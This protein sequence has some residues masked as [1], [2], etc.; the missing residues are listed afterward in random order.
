M[1]LSVK[2]IL[3][4]LVC[5]ATLALTGCKKSSS[6]NYNVSVSVSGLLGTGLYLQLNYVN[7]TQPN[8]AS[9]APVIANGVVTFPNQLPN[10]AVY[11]VNV[12][13]PPGSP[14]QNCTLAN[15]SGTIA[16]AN[17][18]NITLTCASV[19]F[20]YLVNSAANQI[21]PY[22][23]DLGTGML[24][25]SG[26]SLSAGTAPSALAL[27]PTGRYAY[28]VSSTDSTM[29]AYLGNVST[30]QLI[31]AGSAVSTGT[32]GNPSAVVVEP[33]SQYVYVAN[34][35][36]GTVAGF[37]INSASAA[38]T[39]LGAVAGVCPATPTA[40]VGAAPAAMTVTKSASGS[41]YLFVVNS[42]GNSVSEFAINSDGSLSGI[43]AA[44]TGN[45][46]SAIAATPGSVTYVYVTN[47]S[48]DTVSGY[49]NNSG[50]LAANS[51]TALPA[52][53]MPS[54]LA[55][56]PNGKFAY[57][58][59]S[60]NSTV[61]AFSIDGTGALVGLGTP[62]AAGTGN[63]PV[64]VSVDASGAYAYV[65]S[66]NSNT[67]WLYKINTDGTLTAASSQQIGNA[68]VAL[69]TAAN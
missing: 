56:T 16:D 68:P 7:G 61:A 30:G 5:C 23:I 45:N 50:A 20:A 54:A 64:S 38:V 33:G 52:G 22:T 8:V 15:A 12:L 10:N 37:A 35:T 58:A 19:G 14:F 63:Q 34:Q 49:I 36:S 42:G 2:N 24:N 41:E 31:S 55:I 39:C 40:T 62:L 11:A 59:C 51:T 53:S 69:V 32:G 4:V 67:V 21:A 27:S 6:T 3:V 47:T 17:V 28:A 26:P 29:A 48:D 60:G 43:G 46:P 13:Y 66:K 65:V 1:K 44:A 9:G 25:S 18:T 57:V